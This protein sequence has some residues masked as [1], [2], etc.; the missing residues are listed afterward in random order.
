MLVIPCSDSFRPSSLRV[1]MPSAR[2]TL[3]ISSA[4]LRSTISRSI[5]SVT[6][7]IS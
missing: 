5:A 7:M 6:G 1:I 4:L 3:P 2:A